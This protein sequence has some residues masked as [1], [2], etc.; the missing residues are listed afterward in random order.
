MNSHYEMWSLIVARQWELVQNFFNVMMDL[1]EKVDVGSPLPLPRPLEH[2]TE[3]LWF[4]PLFD[5]LQL[6]GG[7]KLVKN[8][9]MYH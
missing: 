2:A 9:D 8:V 7:R 1:A 4:V 6:E 5:H 3:H